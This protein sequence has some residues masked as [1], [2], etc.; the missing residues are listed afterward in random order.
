MGARGA[1]RRSSV[2]ISAELDDTPLS[3]RPGTPVTDTSG[4]RFHAST[5]S[6]MVYS[7]SPTITAS[8]PAPK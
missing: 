6:A 3:T 2:G 7:G 4:S 5:N 8:A 1:V